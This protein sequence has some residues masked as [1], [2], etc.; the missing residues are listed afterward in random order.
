LAHWL[1]NSDHF[2]PAGTLFAFFMSDHC[3]LQAFIASEVAAVVGEANATKQTALMSAG[4]IRRVFIANIH[5]MAE[6]FCMIRQWLAVG[7]S[8]DVAGQRQ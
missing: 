3:W 2:S 7:N 8:T 5:H 6:D 4:K 1:Q